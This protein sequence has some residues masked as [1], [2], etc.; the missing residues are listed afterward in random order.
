[1]NRMTANLNDQ[2]ST[3]NI[4]SAQNCTHTQVHFIFRSPHN[5]KGHQ[6]DTEEGSGAGPTS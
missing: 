3:Q 2:P 4:Y 6:C 5:S 1:M